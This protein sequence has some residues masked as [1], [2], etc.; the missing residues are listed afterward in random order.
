MVNKKKNSNR[1]E[2]DPEFGVDS[3]YPS[4]KVRDEE[5]IALLEARLERLKSLSPEQIIHAKLMQLKLRMEV[6]LEQHDGSAS[7]KFTDFLE[8]YIDA[9]YSKRSSFAK[10]INVTP[11]N[12][13]QVI[14]NHR[15]PTQEFLFKL[16]IHSEKVY[17]SVTSFDKHLWLAVYLHEQKWKSIIEQSEWKP[18]LEKQVTLSEALI[19]YHKKE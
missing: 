14:N 5:S 1:V 16:M 17:E 12:L 7:D 4:K 18:R 3:R 15:E 2:N 19:K 13:S 11:V 8:S 10:D 9:V 6:F